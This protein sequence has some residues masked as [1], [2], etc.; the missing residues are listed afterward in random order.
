MHLFLT[1]CKINV[2]TLLFQTKLNQLQID[3]HYISLLWIDLMSGIDM[4]GAHTY[5][6]FTH[7]YIQCMYKQTWV[8]KLSYTLLYTYTY[9]NMYKH[10]FTCMYVCKCVCERVLARTKCTRSV[11]ICFDNRMCENKHTFSLS[12]SFCDCSF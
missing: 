3:P 4:R 2:C 12:L 9:T 7:P 10:W 5:A 1:A 11:T 8:D 6:H